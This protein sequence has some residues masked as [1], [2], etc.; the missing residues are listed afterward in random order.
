MTAT[1]V[2]IAFAG[3][4][5]LGATIVLIAT[6]RHAVDRQILD[7]VQRIGAIHILQGREI[8]RMERLT[9]AVITVST[10]RPPPADIGGRLA[11]TMTGAWSRSRV[12]VAA[13]AAAATGTFGSPPA[14][15]AGQ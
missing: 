15:P 9:M 1:Y 3:G 10:E 4:V 7:Q 8:P 2:L 12:G 5:V 11:M 6:R 14:G 13:A